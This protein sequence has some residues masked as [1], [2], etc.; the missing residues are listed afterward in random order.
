M[1]W[2]ILGIVVFVLWLCVRY[3]TRAGFVGSRSESDKRSRRV[4]RSTHVRED[5]NPACPSC[6]VLLK[7]QPK[8]KKRCPACGED[9]Y[10]RFKQNLFLSCLLTRENALCSD[11][12][13]SMGMGKD[14]FHAAKAEL[15]KRF[16]KEPSSTDIIWHLYNSRIIPNLGTHA[17]AHVVYYQMALFNYRLGRPF[18]ELLQQACR[19]ELRSYEGKSWIMRVK[20]RSDGGCPACQKLE[21]KIIGL[22]KALKTMPIPCREC[23]YRLQGGPPGFCRCDYLPVIEDD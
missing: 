10:V 17:N 1:G 18:F 12:L 16:G 11:A 21:G 6:G 15:T 20:I 2:A 7:R 8:R 13:M 22:E 4:A 9:I 14:D 3:A 23:T 5:A 19:S